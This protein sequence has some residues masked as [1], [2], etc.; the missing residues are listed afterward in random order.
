MPTVTSALLRISRSSGDGPVGP[1]DDANAVAGAVCE[2]PAGRGIGVVDDAAAGGKGS[3][4][5]RLDVLPSDGHIDVHRMPERLVRVKFLHPDRRAV[6]ERVDGVAVS[7]PCVPEDCA[8]ETDFD[9][10]GLRSYRQLN[11]LN[12]C[13]VGEGTLRPRDRRDCPRKVD[14]TLLQPKHTAAQPHAEMIVG[15][16][17]KSARTLEAG[18]VRDRLGKSRRFAERRDAEHSSR[19]AVQHHPVVNAFSG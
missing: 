14:V 15:E 16:R 4:H 13:A 7:Q 6:A 8:P 5:S 3:R 11:L 9:R 18:D 17:Q 10:L 1:C 12:S 19:S 2:D